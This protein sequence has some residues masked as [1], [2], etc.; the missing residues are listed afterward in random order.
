MKKALLLALA[1][2]PL[3]VIGQ[4]P[5]AVAKQPILVSIAAKGGDVRAVI[6]DLFT[7]S[8]QNYV[9]QPGILSSI[10]LQLDKIEF[11]EALN[12][13]CKQAQ[14][15]FEIQ[16]GIYYIAKKSTVIAPAI[17][18]K[19]KGTL[20]SAALAHPITTKLVKTDIRL[21]FAEFGKQ[22]K[23]AI[24]VDPSVP[25][26]K[27]DAKLTALSLKSALDKVTE[28]TGLKYRLTNNLSILVYKPEDS[29]RIAISGN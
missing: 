2:V 29:N 22:A 23:V 10:F 7:Q 17:P 19:P 8:K 6:A 12:I 15:Q 13:V 20:D 5:P 24:E 14:L 21:V 11:E 3:L 26:Y 16:N 25:R 27:L 18:P 28:A 9:L 1:L 4:D